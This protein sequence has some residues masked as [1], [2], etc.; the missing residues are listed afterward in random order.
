MP[1]D[2]TVAQN[3]KARHEYFIL[4]SF[5]VGI[6]L[7]GTEIKSVRDGRVNLKDGFAAVE[8]G[9]LW[10][11]NVHISPYEKGTIYNKDPLRVRKLLVHKAEIRRLVEKTREKGLTLVPLK[12]YLKEGRRAK[13]ELAVAK[14]KQ[15]HDKRDSA[16]ERDAER[17]MSR[18]LRRRSRGEDD[19]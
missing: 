14:G 8:K 6:V 17:E 9:E 1:D 7:S 16:A 10:L 13:I 11:Y 5:E 4:D 19:Y 12:M 2:K 18:A 3:R 15:L